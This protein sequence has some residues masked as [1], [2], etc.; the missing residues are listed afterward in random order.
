MPAP[1]V[2]AGLLDLIGKAADRFFP[3][4]V[5]A[6][7][8]KLNAA[9]MAQRGEF[10]EIDAILEGDRGQIAVNV[11]EAK[12]DDLFKSGWRPYVG[13]VC[14]GG[15]SYQ[16]VLRPLLEWAGANLWEWSAPPSLEM[17]TLLTLLF[18]LLGLGYYRTKERL[19]GRIQ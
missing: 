18:G 2:V 10:K 1:L 9:E 16:F 3:D 7:Q 5:A 6:A 12:S 14:G 11:E 19:A 8:F 4:P 17:E 13:W 15:L